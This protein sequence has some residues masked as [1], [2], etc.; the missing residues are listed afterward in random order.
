VTVDG[1]YIVTTS[2]SKEKIDVTGKP[3]VEWYRYWYKIIGPDQLL[4]EKAASSYFSPERK[5][6]EMGWVNEP[7]HHLIYKS[8]YE[9]CKV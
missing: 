5:Y 6:R 8:I 7:E 1:D 4:F 9:V 3:I 2:V